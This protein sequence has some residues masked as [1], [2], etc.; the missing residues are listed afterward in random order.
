MCFLK[1]TPWKS[2]SAKGMNGY[3]VIQSGMT[4]QALIPEKTIK[5]ASLFC[6]KAGK[7]PS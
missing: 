2:A 6:L 5:T 3:H 1:T 4:S 7:I